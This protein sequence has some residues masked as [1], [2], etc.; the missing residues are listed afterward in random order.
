MFRNIFLTLLLIF[1]LLFVFMIPKKDTIIS[2]FRISNEP[3]VIS[4]GNYGQSLIV[5][6]SFS[7]DGINKWIEQLNKPYPLFMLDADWI[8]RSPETIDIIKRKNIPTGLYGGSGEKFSVDMFNKEVDIYVKHFKS[9]PLW[10]MTSDYKY[11]QNLKQAAFNEQINLLSP[12][13]IYSNENQNHITKGS[14]IAIQV[15]EPS[16]PNFNEITKFIN[17]NQFIS[18]EENIFG[19]KMKS[20]KSP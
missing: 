1:I 13:F 4:K 6:I 16:K 11:S 12:T 5:E 9:K 18:I 19:Y 10:Y 3:L 7:H 20:K 15:H 14:I 8:E 17:S 2:A